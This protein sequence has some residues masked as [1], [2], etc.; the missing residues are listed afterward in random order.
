MRRS[1]NVART[2]TGRK[3]GKIFP[4]KSIYKGFYFWFGDEFFILTIIWKINSV[5]LFWVLFST[6][7]NLNLDLKLRFIF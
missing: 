1:Q 5:I 7:R 4:D 2:H 3:R 6:K